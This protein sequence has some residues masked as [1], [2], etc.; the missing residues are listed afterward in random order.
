MANKMNTIGMPQN[1]RNESLGHAFRF[2][3]A[4]AIVIAGLMACSTLA[5]TPPIILGPPD[6]GAEHGFDFWYHGTSGTGFLSVDDT[7]PATGDNDFTL[8]NDTPGQGNCADWRSQ[9]F[10]LGAAADN[11]SPITFSFVYQL[12]DE[13]KEGENVRVY[14]RFFDAT[15]TNYL[16]ARTIRI[17]SSTGDSNMTSY[18]SVTLTNIHAQQGA[19]TADIWITAN[20]F[21]KWTSGTARFDDF[22]VTTALPQHPMRMSV[23]ILL[24]LGIVLAILATGWRWRTCRK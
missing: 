7:E 21:E 22:S 13:I 3:K 11:G 12:P 16:S 18:K 5:M 10:P 6:P 8:G 23:K 15:G 2:M 14:L 4:V 24:G 19:K 20:I 1:F 17:G 9:N